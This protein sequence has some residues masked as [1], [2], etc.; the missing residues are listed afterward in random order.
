MAKSM[1]TVTLHGN[2]LALTGTPVAVGKPAP[3]A[4][5]LDGGLAPVAISDV[6]AGK[7]A[8]IASV[9]SLDTPICDAETRRFNQEASALGES[10]VV[11]VISVDL[12]FAQVRWCGAAGV[13]RV[14]VLSDYRDTAFG[15]AWGIL[16]SDLRLLARAVWVVDSSGTVRYA[17]I[18][19][20]VSQAP[21]YEQ[22]LR[23]VRQ[24]LA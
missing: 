4:V 24:T 6:I 23:A 14:Q 1:R 9:P 11:A 8:V 17:Q 5:V 21:E 7:T 13:D 16:I 22:V 19:P 15:Q 20:E 3:D 18:V 2:P 10:V 12:P